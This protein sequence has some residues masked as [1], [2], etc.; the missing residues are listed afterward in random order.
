M[1]VAMQIATYMGMS[2]RLLQ[3]WA[4]LST[5]MRKLPFGGAPRAFRNTCGL[6]QRLFTSVLCAELSVSLP[7]W[8]MT[9]SLASDLTLVSYG[10]DIHILS[11]SEDQLGLA[12]GLVKEFEEVMKLTL[13]TKKT[14]VWGSSTPANLRISER[15]DI[16]P[17]LTCEALGEE[18]ATHRG[19][20]MEHKREVA[21]LEERKRRLERIRHVPLH[22]YREMQAISVACMSLVDL[23]N[24]P[25]PTPYSKLRSEV[26]SVLGLSLASPEIACNTL[27]PTLDPEMRWLFAGLRLW[28]EIL[29]VGSHLAHLELALSKKGRLGLIARHARDKIG[30]QIDTLEFLM[31]DMSA[32]V[33][34]QWNA[35]KRTI[36]DLF[37]S[38]KDLHP[39]AYLLWRYLS[40]QP[41]EAFFLFTSLPSYQASTLLKLWTGGVVTGQ[42]RTQMGH[43]TS[44]SCGMEHPSVYHVL[45]D[46]EMAPPPPPPPHLSTLLIRNADAV[47]I[48]HWKQ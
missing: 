25:P 19:A 48:Q 44:C 15:Y 23:V 4:Y 6:L 46:C 39:K 38:L 8:R 36:L 11:T 12:L 28:H 24:L 42:K 14:K 34:Q 3:R 29:K 17:S 40:D 7:M 45:W 16:S 41:Q 21:R 32:R 1:L 35:A 27:S 33:G 5:G 47:E 20:Q 9:R 13:S 2:V 37:G 18:W 22:P 26:I 43:A 31:A 10:D 30:I